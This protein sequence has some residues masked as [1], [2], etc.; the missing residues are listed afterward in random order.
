MGLRIT[1]LSENNAS[2]EG[3]LAEWGLSVLIETGERDILFDTGL[4]ISASRN[5]DVLG[6][7]TS[8]IDKIVLSHGH[9]DHTGGLRH[10]LSKMKKNVEIIAHPDIWADKYSLHPAGQSRYIG[11]PFK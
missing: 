4:S 8:R 9:Y 2:K 6:I 7:D 5:I 1:T 3:L 10:I 11:I